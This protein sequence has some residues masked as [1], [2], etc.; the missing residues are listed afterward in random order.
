LTPIFTSTATCK[1]A[2]D[3]SILIVTHNSAAWLASCLASIHAATRCATEVIVVDNAS[4][5]ATLPA[6]RSQCPS[7]VVVQNQENVGFATATNQAS[8]VARGRHLLLLNPDSVILDDALD[9]LVA[10]MDAHPDVGICA[11][12]NLDGAGALKRNCG[13]IS[14]PIGY[15]YGALAAPFQPGLQQLLRRVRPARGDDLA[16]DAPV[17]VQ[18]V[19]G[20]SLCIR[21]ELYQALNGLDERFFMYI[22]DVD[23]CLRVKRQGWRV[24]YL[25]AAR[26]IHYGGHSSAQGGQPRLNGMLVPY[27]TSA[28]YHYVVKNYGRP[29]LW[30][31]RAANALSGLC[32]IG[33]SFLAGSADRRKEKRAIGRALLTARTPE[34]RQ[35]AHARD[36]RQ[37]M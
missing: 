19:H 15:I 10:F 7:A 13:R 26:V 34:P 2:L 3:L 28:R 33:L 16:G 17:D 29:W 12:R 1:P 11:P 30:P 35:A 21:R 9:V 4:A 22:E 25:P 37:P 14:T 36:M 5:D 32:W 24:V 27:V 31:L 8:R 6:A 23:I 18:V 20:N